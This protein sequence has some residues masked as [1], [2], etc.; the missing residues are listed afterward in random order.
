[1]RRLSPLTAS[2][3]RLALVLLAVAASGCDGT[4]PD[5]LDSQLVVSASLGV[6]EPLPPIT[7]SRVSPL[8]DTYDPASV[9]VGGARVTVSLLAPDG[10][11]EVAYPY[12]GADPT[13]AG[14]YRP[15]V[16]AVGAVVAVRP[17]RRYRLDVA[18]GAETLTAET[19][20][21]PAV[22]LVEGPADEVAYGENQGPELRISRSSTPERKAT[23]VATT[24]A[25]APAEY[26]RVTVDGETFYRSVPAPDTYLPVPIYRRFLDCKDEPAGTILCAENPRSVDVVTG[27]S[28]VI[29]EASYIDLG[30]GT[31]LVQVPFIGFGYYGPYRVS[32]VSL[33]AALEAFV[34]AQ[35]V[36]GGGSTLSPGEIPNLVTNVEGGL[37]VF[38]SFARVTVQTTIVEP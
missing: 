28:P 14:L 19:L 2:A 17:G 21:P 8:L 15:D 12:T 23:F 5:D 9:A 34:E 20:T 33:D 35:L 11:V 22:T 32:L 25:L 18:V 30:D 26:E 38:G 29:N 3:A 37:G 16:A 4:A 1:M 27:T 6:N 13:N 10:S 36:Q 7:L 24:L 31:L